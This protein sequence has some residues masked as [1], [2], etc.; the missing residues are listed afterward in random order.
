MKFCCRM[1]VLTK[2]IELTC[3]FI[4]KNYVVG[5]HSDTYDNE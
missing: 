4:D 1:A 3:H 5:V 2:V